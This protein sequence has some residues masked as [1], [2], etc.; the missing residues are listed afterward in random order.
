M[1]LKGSRIHRQKDVEKLEPCALLVGMENS[2]EIKQKF[3]IG[4][5][6]ETEIPLLNTSNW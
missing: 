2:V 6:Y 3:K 5:L 1:W 4:L